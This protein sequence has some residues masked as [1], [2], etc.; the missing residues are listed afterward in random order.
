M[1]VP[2]RSL[3]VNGVGLDRPLIII[4]LDEVATEPGAWQNPSV[5]DLF[6]PGH[7]PRVPA[8]TTFPPFPPW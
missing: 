4:P 1:Q 7:S 8:A 6:L 2:V 5:G 3:L